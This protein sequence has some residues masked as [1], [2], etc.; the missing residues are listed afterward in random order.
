MFERRDQHKNLSYKQRVETTEYTEYANSDKPNNKFTTWG[1]QTFYE[2]LCKAKPFADALASMFRATEGFLS[3]YCC[4][5]QNGATIKV[6]FKEGS[7]VEQFSIILTHKQREI[8]ET[9]PITIETV[10][11]KKV[12]RFEL[13]EVVL[14]GNDVS[15]EP[16]ESEEENQ[17]EYDRG[18][19]VNF[20]V[21]TSVCRGRLGYY[22]LWEDGYDIFTAGHIITQCCDKNRSYDAQPYF[23]CSADE[24][25]PT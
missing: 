6:R 20:A 17:I 23:T 18:C 4:V 9:Y 22:V 25:I 10:Y 7:K 16:K 21:G 1:V 19:R 5:S 3:T 11:F 12:C 13:V 2:A 24:D 14:K 15:I 8:L